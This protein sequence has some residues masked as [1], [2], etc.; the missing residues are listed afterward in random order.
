MGLPEV[1]ARLS[2][3]APSFFIRDKKT[4]AMFHDNHHEDG[5]LGVW[6]PAPPGVQAQV[7]DTQPDRFYVPAYVGHRGWLGI[8][9][10]NDPDWDEVKA[11]LV[12]AYRA[13]APKKLVALLSGPVAG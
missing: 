2:H 8:R 13:V 9:L 4:L 12:E 3:G 11:V 7:V 6:C 10:N 1:S 5:E